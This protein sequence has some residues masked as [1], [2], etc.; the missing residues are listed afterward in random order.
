MLLIADSGS[1]KC[2]WVLFKNKEEEPIKIRTEGLNP[3][4]LKEE[5][6]LEVISNSTALIQHKNEI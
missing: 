3:S 4:I 5:I 6:L 2:D 1:T